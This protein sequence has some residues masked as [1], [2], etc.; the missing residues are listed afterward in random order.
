[1]L[2]YICESCKLLNISEINLPLKTQFFESKLTKEKPLGKNQI[3]QIFEENDLKQLMDEKFAIIIN[4]HHRATPS[5][6]ILR[7]LIQ[8]Y[9]KN[10]IESI[11]IATGTHSAPSID[12]LNHLIDKEIQDQI[13]IIIH[14]AKQSDCIY[15]G[16]T[17]SGTPIKINKILQ[18]FNNILC[19]NSV[20]PHYFAGFTGGI[21][22]IFP[23]LGSYESIIK[24]HSL[25]LDPHTGPSITENNPLFNDLWEVESMID[26]NIF[27][28]Q[29]VCEGNNIFS[30][31]YGSLRNS[32]NQAKEFAM[33]VL[34]ITTKETFD[35]VVSVV[36]APL[37]MSL[38]QAQ[39]GIENTKKLVTKGGVL[40]L[41]AK[42]TEGIGNEN[43]YNTIREYNTPEHVLQSLNLSNY[44]FG[45]HKV[46]NFAKFTHSNTL[47]IIS[48][49]SETEL[50]HVFANSLSINRLEGY[51]QEHSEQGKS[52]AVVMDSG[53]ICI[54]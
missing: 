41:L 49:L 35:V 11:I 22:S 21:K 15:L 29:M 30:L 33:N 16:T 37:N 39:K 43:F 6:K 20:E 54:I 34:T 48:N 23:G 38:Y 50:H 2:F 28:I 47:F 14:D 52:I 8:T 12:Q 7:L 40:I 24:N 46:Y 44:K 36:Y 26:S 5:K 31:S 32:F 13:P 45:D 42:C 10:N 17:K 27:G 18:S 25:A 51:L 4:D 9:G 1:M 53:N 3:L 19:I